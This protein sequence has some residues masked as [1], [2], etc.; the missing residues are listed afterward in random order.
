MEK[1]VLKKANYPISLMSRLLGVSRQGFHAPER[2]AP[3]QRPAGR[4]L[5]RAH[6]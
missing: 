4:L 5:N 3:S 1:E 2:R 6:P